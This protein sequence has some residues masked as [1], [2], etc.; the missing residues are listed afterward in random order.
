LNKAADVIRGFYEQNNF[1]LADEVG[2]QMVPNGGDGNFPQFG[3]A[4]KEQE[5]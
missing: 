5:S 4:H 2:V 3:R 1:V